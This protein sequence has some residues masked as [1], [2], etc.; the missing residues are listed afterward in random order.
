[1]LAAVA[2]L[3]AEWLILTRPRRPAYSP[4]EPPCATVAGRDIAAPSAS[5]P[6]G[7]DDGM[8][9]STMTDPAEVQLLSAYP[10]VARYYVAAHRLEGDVPADVEQEA[11]TVFRARGDRSSGG[12]LVAIVQA[13]EAWRQ[14]SGTARR[15][16]A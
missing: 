1:V 7:K 12:A 6:A 8:A 11:L 13:L 3:A 4:S 5:P 9:L 14:R 10:S 16:A 15:H 2:R